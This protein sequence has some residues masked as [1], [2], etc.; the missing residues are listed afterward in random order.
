MSDRT[1]IIGDIHGCRS[2]LERLLDRL[3]PTQDETLVF[4]GDYVDRGPDSP[5]V[6]ARLLQL[7]AERP[8]TVFLRGNHDEMLLSFLRLVEH[9]HG[10]AYL[11][12]ANGGVS[13]LE[14]Y[15]CPPMA[16]SW[17]M[18]TGAIP[19]GDTLAELRACFPAEHLDFL[20]STQLYYKTDELLCVHAGVLPGV[21]LEQQGADVLLW[22]REEF[23]LGPNELPQTIV[24]GHTPT[25]DRGFEPRWDCD[26]RKVG[27]DTGCVYGGYLTA[28][29]WPSRETVRVRTS[30][31]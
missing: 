17:C 2:E 12:T 19:D 11:Y 22:V 10:Y 25:H 31:D 26:N 4:L 3:A 29:R 20:S 8:D 27:I 6:I 15:G 23:I 16:V 14:Q 13:T 9:G 28:L 24:Y 7:R 18:H 1:I 30:V 21:P 5:G